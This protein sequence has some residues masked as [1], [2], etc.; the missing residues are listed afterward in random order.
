MSYPSLDGRI[1]RDVTD[2][3]V[4]DVGE[5]TTFEYH[6]HEDHTVWA[7]Y[8]GGAVRLGYLVGVRT[9]D[10]LAFRYVHITLSGETAAGRC[11]S[12]I[13]QLPD[14]R[15]RM[16]ETWEWESKAGSGTSVVEE[17]R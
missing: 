6:Q 1:F 15:L 13:E 8:E 4:G 16:C 17:L 7:R 9:D 11:T 14:G 12:T 5:E 10:S 3:R 2:V